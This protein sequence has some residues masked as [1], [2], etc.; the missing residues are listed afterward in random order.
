VI[1]EGRK[2]RELQDRKRIDWLGLTPSED[3]E[4]LAAIRH[5]A[6]RI[7]LR[8]RMFRSPWMRLGT[9]PGRN[10]TKSGK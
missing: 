7:G 10:V 9:R 5:K 6:K 3:E 4:P 8:R 2:E 1:E